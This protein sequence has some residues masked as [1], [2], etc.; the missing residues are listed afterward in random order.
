MNVIRPNCRVHFTAAD[1]AFVAA[2]ASGP[3]R[4]VD[5]VEFVDD[6]L[7]DRAVFTALL[8]QPSCLNV[9]SHLYFYVLV[10]H[11]MLENGIDDRI[12]AD[13]VAEMMAE[14]SSTDRARRPLAPDPRA[15]DH[16]VDL[17]TAIRDADG[18]RQFLLRAHVGNLSLFLSGVF[19]KHLEHRARVKAAPEIEFYE[20]VGA[21]S[22][23]TAGDHPLAERYEVAPV[24][25]TLSRTFRETRVVLNDLTDRL[26]FLG[27]G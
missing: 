1:M 6:M 2:A 26:I 16:M 5:G 7:D 14:F 12:L 21:S 24:F 18:P 19:S 10:R 4:L 22:Y 20:Q 11:V 3:G 8:E 25:Q 13:Y 17:L 23:R 9:S 27:E 15:F